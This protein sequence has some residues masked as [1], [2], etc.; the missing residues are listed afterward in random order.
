VRQ[1]TRKIRNDLIAQI[2]A[3]APGQFVVVQINSRWRVRLRLPNKIVISVLLVR[4]ITA[5]KGTIRWIVDPNLKERT[6]PTLLARLREGSTDFNKLSRVFQNGKQARFR[7]SLHDPWLK[8][9][10]KLE[11]LSTLCDAVGSLR[12]VSR[13]TTHK[14][15]G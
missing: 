8:S 2:V 5:W 1:R 15:Y 7:L 10:I 13:K 3:S 9:G 6:L 14:T 12:R 11:G 4:A